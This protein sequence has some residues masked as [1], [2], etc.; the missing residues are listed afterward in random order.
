M[1]EKLRAAIDDG[2]VDLVR[3]IVSA[4][5]ELVKATDD[6]GATALMH[7]AGSMGPTRPG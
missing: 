1:L 4:H 2:D 3:Q 5:P 7:A 6:R